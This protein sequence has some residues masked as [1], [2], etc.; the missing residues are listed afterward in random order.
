MKPRLADRANKILDQ[1][2]WKLGLDALTSDDR[3]LSIRSRELPSKGKRHRIT[4]MVHMCAVVVSLPETSL[5]RDDQARR[6]VSDVTLLL[7]YY[8]NQ[9]LTLAKTAH[10]LMS[11]G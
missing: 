5:V 4:Y 2:T 10:S 7:L 9:C 8:T 3:Y 11:A 6:I 1:A